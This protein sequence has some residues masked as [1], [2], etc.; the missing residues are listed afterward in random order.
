M[1]LKPMLGLLALPL[2]AA[3]APQVETT[4]QLSDVAKVLGNGE[5]VSEPLLLSIP[6]TSE[7]DCKKDL[8]TLIARLKTLAPVT[9]KG[10]CTTKDG[11]EVAEIETALQVV[12]PKTKI[13]AA[14]LFALVVDHDSDGNATLSFDVLKRIADIIQTLAGDDSYSTDFDPTKFVLHVWN[15]GD[16][17]VDALP[18]EVF[19]DGEPHL[20]VDPPVTIP[21][22]EQ[23][24][25][26]FND[27][28]AT[29]TEKGNAYQFVTVALPK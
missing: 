17:D 11:D 24:E 4:I 18:G 21:G 25:V 2:L 19:V 1:N 9:G 15:D 20:G 8:D 28:A 6:Q 10:Q 12:T 22:G 3:C 29:F 5:A 26:R 13:G 27:V 14:N 7:D 23:I 16:N